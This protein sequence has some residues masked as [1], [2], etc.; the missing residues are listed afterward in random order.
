M[1]KAAIFDMDGTVLDSMPMW[2]QFG[3]DYLS[4]QGIKAAENLDRVLFPM[5][6]PQT[7]RYFIDEYGLDKSVPRILS[8]MDAIQFDYYANRAE[9]KGDVLALLTELKEKGIKLAIATA[10][11]LKSTLAGLEHTG[12]LDFFECV[13]TV[14]D[15][16]V[17]KESPAVFLEA[18]KR[19][20]C[21]PEEAVVF[22]DALHASLTAQGAGFPVVGIYEETNHYFAAELEETCDFYLKDYSDRSGLYEFMGL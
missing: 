16:G 2:Q 13:V 20:R 17:G 11:D 8:E 5:T 22:E 6:A 15:V 14:F 7:A 18:A 4:R 1:I 21:A 3:A 12:V 19:L 9:L 10:T